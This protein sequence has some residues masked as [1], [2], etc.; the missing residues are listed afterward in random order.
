[1]SALRILKK[2]KSQNK[3]NPKKGLA[4]G[5][6]SSQPRSRFSHTRRTIPEFKA[7]LLIRAGLQKTASAAQA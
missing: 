1:M 5:S 3:P 6:Y 4:G 7:S 2:L